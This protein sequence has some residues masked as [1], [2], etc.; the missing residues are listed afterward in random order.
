MTNRSHH[1]SR[2]TARVNRG[3]AG[4]TTFYS[5]ESAYRAALRHG[6]PRYHRTHCAHWHLTSQD[7]QPGSGA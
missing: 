3:C 4:K 6:H 7:N 1:K 2:H 5:Q